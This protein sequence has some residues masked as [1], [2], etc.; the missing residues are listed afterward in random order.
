MSAYYDRPIVT[1]IEPAK[2]FYPAEVY[3]QFYYQKNPEHYDAYKEG[4][5]R[6]GYVRKKWGEKKE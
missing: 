2:P 5:G 3:H 6:A 1:S 4:S